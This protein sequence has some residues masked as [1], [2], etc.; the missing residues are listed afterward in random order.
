MY[1]VDDNRVLYPG[2]LHLGLYSYRY[3]VCSMQEIFRRFQQHGDRNTSQDTHILNFY[4]PRYLNPPSN[5]WGLFTLPGKSF[6]IPIYPPK[7]FGKSVSRVKWLA[8]IRS[9]L[10]CTYTY[11]Y[12]YRSS[13]T[14]SDIRTFSKALLSSSS[15]KASKGLYLKFYLIL[16][17]FYILPFISYL[18][19]ASVDLLL[20]VFHPSSLS[21]IFRSSSILHLLSFIIFCLYFIFRIFSY[22]SSFIF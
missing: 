1:T 7:W 13:H 17:I 22:Q 14:Y 10:V 12:V 8:S 2:L 9:S 21:F 16:S 18:V 19:Y 4:R 5:H 11:R 15:S 3:V 20:S 6:P